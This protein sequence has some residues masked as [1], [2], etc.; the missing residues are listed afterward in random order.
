MTEV[1]DRVT[2]VLLLLEAVSTRWKQSHFSDFDKWVSR[3]G[4]ENNVFG[5]SEK[6]GR[7][8]HMELSIKWSNI[9]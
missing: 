5:S 1:V 9:K 7:R 6:K 4:L 8:K 3:E 2:F